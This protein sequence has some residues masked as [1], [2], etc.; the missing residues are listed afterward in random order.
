M[1]SGPDMGA[2][3]LYQLS[4]DEENPGIAAFR[5]HAQDGGADAAGPPVG[6]PDFLGYEHPETACMFG[7]PRCWERTFFVSPEALPKVRAAY[8]RTRFA[9]AAMLGHQYE[10]LPVPWTEGLQEFLV[11]CDGPLRKARLPYRLMGRAAE[12][13]AI[14]APP[15][16]ALRVEV[17][18]G[19]AGVVGDAL[20]PFLIEPVANRGPEEGL[21]GRA[22]LGTFKAGLRIDF[23][24]PPAGAGEAHWAVREIAW[25][26]FGVPI[27]LPRSP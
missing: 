16:N 3:F 17:G 22:F 6:P 14:G 10:A 20:E 18:E 7:G 1:L 2:G 23:G 24:E 25:A 27:S 5:F 13:L 9:M 19:G 4:V 8:Q 21:G 12:W 11:R 15:P 26:G